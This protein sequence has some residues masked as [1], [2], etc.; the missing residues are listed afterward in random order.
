MPKP[1]REVP[2]FYHERFTIAIMTG[3]AVPLHWQAEQG[4]QAFFAQVFPREILEE[5][6]M[7]YLLGVDG[8]GAPVKIRMDLIENMPAPVK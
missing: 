1:Y 5:N 4:S 6:G 7:D 3:E 2:R 8:E